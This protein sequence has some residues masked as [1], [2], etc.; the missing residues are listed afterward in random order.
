MYMHA[1]QSYVWNAIVSERLSKYGYKPI[2]GDLVFDKDSLGKKGKDKKT[3]DV[4]KDEETD[5]DAADEAEV[6]EGN[7]TAHIF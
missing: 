1:Y 5:V 3:E 4:A 6:E 2:V 7:K